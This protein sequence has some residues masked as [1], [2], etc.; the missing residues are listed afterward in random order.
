MPT[1]TFQRVRC[2]ALFGLVLALCAAGPPVLA[3][4]DSGQLSGFVR[5]PQ[6]GVVPGA[7]VKVLNDS[8]KAERSYTSDNSGYFVA[9]ALPPGSYRVEIQLAGFRKYV[10][11]GVKLDAASKVQVDAVLVPGGVDEEVTVVAEAT[12][13]QSNTG[14]VSKTIE[15]R[16]I[17]DLTTGGFNINGSR[18][19]E[20]LITIDGAVATRTRSSGAIIGTVNVDTVQEIQVLTSS[21]L[22]EYGRS[23]GG[24]IRFVTKGGGHDFHADLY[25]FYRDDKLDANSWQRNNSPLPEQSGKPAPYS[26][27][28]VLTREMINAALADPVPCSALGYHPAIADPT[29]TGSHG[30]HVTDIL[31]DRFAQGR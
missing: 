14:Q 18:G 31:A 19:D 9:P 23:S 12:P 22:A 24:Q 4:F 7:T 25:E 1:S 30:T 5:D 15:T 28:R 3:Q 2:L 13:L 26:Q 11:T 20:N 8:T 16:Q 6:G 10:R 29:N 21:Y 27:G 17:Q